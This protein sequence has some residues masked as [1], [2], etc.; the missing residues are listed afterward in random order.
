M[1]GYSSLYSCI[2][3][4][5]ITASQR[6]A[7]PSRWAH[8]TL[9]FPY[10]SLSKS[11]SVVRA[12]NRFSL[13]FPSGFMHSRHFSFLTLLPCVAFPG[14]SNPRHQFKVPD[15]LLSLDK[16][17]QFNHSFVLGGGFYLILTSLPLSTSPFP[18]SP[19]LCPSWVVDGYGSK[20]VLL[21]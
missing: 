7:I 5:V 10:P 11:P 4:D 21:L 20:V 9:R 8:S 17:H 19:S 13:S 6:N 1:T 2:T 14:S 18:F 16:W 15:S 3:L 12:I